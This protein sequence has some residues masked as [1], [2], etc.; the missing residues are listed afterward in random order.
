MRREPRI[1]GIRRIFRATLGA[2]DVERAVNDEIA[3]HMESRVAEL[4]ARGLTAQAAREQA[5]REYGDLGA[6]RVE[7]A[8][9]DRE[10]LRGERRAAWLDALLHDVRFSLR[11]LRSQPGFAAVAVLVLALGIGANATMFGVV[12]RLLFRPPAHVKEPDRVVTVS[13]LRRRNNGEEGT[14]QVLSYPLY[15]DLRELTPNAFAQVATFSRSKLALG[16]GASA[17]AVNAMRVSANY[18]ATL[19]TQP[20][21]GRFFLPE[22]DGH[23]TGAEVAVLGHAFWRSH[24]AGDPGIV[25]REIALGDGRFTIVGVAPEHFTGIGANA[26]DVWV[27]LTARVSAEEHEGWLNSRQAYWLVVLARLKP[28]VPAERA[29]AEATAALRANEP[30]ARLEA[31][32]PRARLTSVLPRDA[33]AESADARVSLLLGGVSLLVL[34]IACANVATLQL[35]RAIRRRREIAVRLALGIGRARLVRQLLT[36]SVVLALMGGAAAILVARWGGALVRRVLFASITF[37]DDP[38]SGR[39]LIYTAAAALVTGVLTGLLPALQASRPDL[40]GALKSGA[41][42]GRAHQ[43]AT[44]TALLVTQAALTVVLLVGTGLFLRSL[45]EIQAISLGMDVERVIVADVNTTGTDYTRQETFATFDRLLEAAQRTPGVES[46][47]LGT[48]LPFYSSWAEAVSL[49]GRDSLPLTS[50]G[51]PYFQAVTSDFL[52]TMGMQLVRGRSF[53]AADRGGTARVALVNQTAARLWWPG[54]DPIG[55]CM[56]VGGDTMP[57]TEVVGIVANT[58]RQSLLEDETV[59]FFVPI[60]QAPAWVNSRIMFVRTSGEPTRV[61]GSIRR[62]L[63]VAV[64]NLPYVEAET[65]SELISPEMRSWRLGAT[66][67]GAFGLLALVLAAV[68]LYGV[69]AYDVAQRLHEIG[70]RVAL[71]AGARNVAGLVVRA[72]LRVVALGGLIGVAIAGASGGLVAPLLYRTSPRDPAVFGA[73][74]AVLFGVALAATLVP[75]WRAVRVD[76]I[77]ALRAE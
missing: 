73:V 7:L 56:R 58:R 76:P 16:R 12:D 74:V 10:R 54:E 77:T 29:T 22:D 51:G 31:Q 44:R 57:C 60:E 38:V 62:Q 66:M 36:E 5:E 24:F 30:P 2:R 37:V 6:S 55:R 70:V 48:S 65:L 46:A 1:P 41:R 47:A 53:T 34:L 32:N 49:P 25:G 35:A 3:F 45:R 18:F 9:V 28:G 52:R 61:I 19:G 27:P 69:L 14:Q 71:G 4:I 75:A 17:R 50:E 20:A 26:V 11:S 72:G 39:V 67:F 59:M 64:P 15:R 63:Q 13:L 40:T 68:G 43:S 8:A 42:E 21:L 33:N 23:P